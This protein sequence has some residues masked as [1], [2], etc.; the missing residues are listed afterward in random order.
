LQCFAGNIQ[1][2]AISLNKSSQ[3]QA[4]AKKKKGGVVPTAALDDCIA[5]QK[6]FAL[7]GGALDCVQI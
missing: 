5:K 4:H 6:G 3:R 1:A 7:G 2:S